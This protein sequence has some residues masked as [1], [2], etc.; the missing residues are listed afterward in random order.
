MKDETIVEP[1]SLFQRVLVISKSSPVVVNDVIKFELYS[2]PS[3]I[4]ESLAVIRKPTGP[5]ITKINF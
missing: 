3:S 1:S 2:Y 5:E 4:S